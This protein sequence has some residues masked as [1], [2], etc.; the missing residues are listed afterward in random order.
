MAGM[1]KFM[2]IYNQFMMLDDKS[3]RKCVC[4]FAATLTKS[5]IN[6]DFL[7]YTLSCSSGVVLCVFHYI[8]EIRNVRRLITYLFY[9]IQCITLKYNQTQY[10]RLKLIWNVF[11]YCFYCI[12]LHYNTITSIKSYTFNNLTNL[13][14]LQV[15][16]ISLILFL[17]VSCKTCIC[18]IYLG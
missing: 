15:V 5:N 11:V 2:F 13:N 17:S 8:C 4:V 1:F 7:L 18:I 3:F 9:F 6:L 16:S 12:Y 10:Q 14:A